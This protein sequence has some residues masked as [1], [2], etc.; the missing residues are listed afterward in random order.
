[1][2]E[3]P[4]PVPPA[5]RQALELSEGPPGKAALSA[6]GCVVCSWRVIACVVCSRLRGPLLVDA[7]LR[8]LLLMAIGGLNCVQTIVRPKIDVL[9]SEVDS[10]RCVQKNR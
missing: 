7:R 10:E 9:P 1:L 5:T 8:C 6:L 2:P 4:P 3:R